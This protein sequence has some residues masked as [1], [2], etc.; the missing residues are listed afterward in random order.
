MRVHDI[1]DQTAHCDHEQTGQEKRRA[2]N[3]IAPGPPVPGAAG[4]AT[5]SPTKTGPLQPDWWPD[6]PYVNGD[7]PY[8]QNNPLN[9][10]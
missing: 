5:K 7:L 9:W 3:G 10:P 6:N 1:H 4:S 8:L 2:R